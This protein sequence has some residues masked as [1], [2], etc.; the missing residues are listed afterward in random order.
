MKK[1]ASEKTGRAPQKSSRYFRLVIPNLTDYTN[2][3]ESQLQ[4]LKQQTLQFLQQ[5]QKHRH[6]QYYSIAVQRHLNNVPHLDIL[7]LYEKSV[8][9]SL[10]RFDKYIKHGDLTTYRKINEC[11]LNYNYKYDKFPLTNLPQDNKKIINLHELKRDPYLFL[12]TKMK[13]DPLHFNLEQYVESSQLSEHISGWSGIKTK[14]KDMQQAAANLILRNKPGFQ[15]ITRELIES[16]LS[17]DQLKLYDSWGGYQ[18]IVNYLNQIP[19]YGYKRPIKTKNL[20]ITGPPNCGKTTLFS[21]R[22]PQEGQTPIANFVSIYPMATK[23]WWPR[24]KSE[25][26]KLIFWNEAKL[27]SYSYDILLRVLEG[28]QVDLPYKGGS[29]LKYDNPLVVMTS[30]L[31]LQQMIS[32]KFNYNSR[33][34]QMANA[35]LNVRVQN[36]ILPQGYD[37]FLIQKLFLP[38]NTLS[39]N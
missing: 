36:V 8:K 29:T 20:L 17:S 15:L 31:T 7:L 35:N 30:N 28:T 13:Q 37:L 23:D 6:L 14:L 2:S 5:N 22:Y 34:Q 18:T 38:L 1:K 10:N 26:Y 3:S 11:I 19:C 32:Q 21:N 9:N 39:I 33:Y 12:Y 16:Q 27:T 25:T 24:Y 4:L